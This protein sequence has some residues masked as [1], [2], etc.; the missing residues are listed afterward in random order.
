M[1]LDHSDRHSVGPIDTIVD[2]P[3]GHRHDPRRH[4][5]NRF[6]RSGTIPSEQISGKRK[7]KREKE[8]NQEE[9]FVMIA[10]SDRL[11]PKTGHDAITRLSRATLQHVL[12][13]SV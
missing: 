11:P 1:S 13:R 9:D 7:K 10:A 12:N 5:L 2:A 6:I 4:R 8:R 3:P